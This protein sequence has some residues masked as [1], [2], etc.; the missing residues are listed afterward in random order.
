MAP[1][2][3]SRASSPVSTAVTVRSTSIA[4]A[5]VALLVS[6]PGRADRRPASVRARSETTSRLSILRSV[7]VREVLTFWSAAI[8][9][10]V[11]ADSCPGDAFGAA[12]GLMGA[13]NAAAVSG[14]DMVATTTN[15]IAPR[16]ERILRYPWDAGRR[17]GE[18]M[19]QIYRTYA[20]S[21]SRKGRKGRM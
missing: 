10:A 11:S 3:R 1:A 20:H 18:C 5:F 2:E 8:W 12:V 9:D 4:F 14:T 21:D 19:I 16:T 17:S 6:T 7:P 15:V 13:A